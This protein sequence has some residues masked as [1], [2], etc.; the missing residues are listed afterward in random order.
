MRFANSWNSIF[1]PFVV[2]PI[3]STGQRREWRTTEV[4]R[5]AHVTFPFKNRVIRPHRRT[6]SFATVV[7]SSDGR[8]AGR[9]DRWTTKHTKSTKVSEKEACDAILLFRLEVTMNRNRTTDHAIREFVELH[10]RA[11]RVLRGRSNGARWSTSRS[12]PWMV[13]G[14]LARPSPSARR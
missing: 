12:A 1:V 10:L 7:E 8:Q 5:R 9:S 13:L 3:E 14:G 6:D 2:A 4:T 11:L